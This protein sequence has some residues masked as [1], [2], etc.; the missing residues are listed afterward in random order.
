MGFRCYRAP[1]VGP[2]RV[3]AVV[4]VARHSDAQSDLILLLLLGQESLEQTT[5][6]RLLFRLLLPFSNASLARTRCSIFFF[7]SFISSL[8]FLLLSSF[9]ILLFSS[10]SQ[11]QFFI[12]SSSEPRCWSS[13]AFV[14]E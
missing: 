6:L 10:L 9:L 2:V 13:P 11:F 3:P 14:D 7:L 1:I 4:S 8:S 5:I 12:L